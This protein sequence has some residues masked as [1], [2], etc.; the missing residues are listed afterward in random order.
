MIISN[1]ICAPSRLN[2][3]KVEYLNCAI[4]DP[5]LL[6]ARLAMIAHVLPTKGPNTD[7]TQVILHYTNKAIVLVKKQVASYVPLTSDTIK[8]ILSLSSLGA[9]SGDL[10]SAKIH[11]DGL[12]A[13]ISNKGR[14]EALIADPHLWRSIFWQLNI[15]RVDFNLAIAMESK[16][17]FEVT[18][19]TPFSPLDPRRTATITRY[20]KR[21]YNLTALP[22]QGEAMIEFCY[23]LRQMIVEEQKADSQKKWPAESHYNRLLYG[24][25]GLAQNTPSSPFDQNTLIY[26][27][28]GYAALAHVIIFTRTE[29]L[30]LHTGPMPRVPSITNILSLRIR[31]ILESSTLLA[32][33][34]AYPEMM[35]WIIMIGGLSTRECIEKKWYATVLA[36]M[37][38]DTGIIGAAELATSLMEFIWS[39]LYLGLHFREFWDAFAM[40]Q[41]ALRCS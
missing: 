8:A 14:T 11:I 32:F 28:F 7:S 38:C 17:R 19:S 29:V 15:Y 22:K 5:A 12:K 23:A 35:L 2:T 33:Q 9:N 25:L 16:P 41:A 40:A 39:D 10:T 24:L 20:K 3:Q 6:H 4:S 21:L 13:L 1:K 27:L 31:A 26:K 36:K 37:G 30:Y 34:M 18:D